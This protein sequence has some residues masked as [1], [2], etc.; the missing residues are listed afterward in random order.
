MGDN[1]QNV[2]IQSMT[3]CIFKETSVDSHVTKADKLRLQVR[4]YFFRR[5]SQ[6]L[7]SGKRSRSAGHSPA[8]QPEHQHQQRWQTSCSS[9]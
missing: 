5:L 3:S 4:V 1:D 7:L 9:S 8:T 6:S 2:A